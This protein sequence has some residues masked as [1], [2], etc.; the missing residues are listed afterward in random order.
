MFAK[1]EHGLGWSTKWVVD[2]FVLRF[3]Y[4]VYPEDDGDRTRTRDAQQELFA[5]PIKS[6]S[7]H[8]T[9]LV[10]FVINAVTRLFRVYVPR[11]VHSKREQT[12]SHI[13]PIVQ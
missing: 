7:D 5:V 8:E 6:D 10:Q 3:F 9:I 11:R 2:S 4:P 1:I 13:L 12:S